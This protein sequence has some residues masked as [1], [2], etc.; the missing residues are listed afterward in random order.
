M[1]PDNAPLLCGSERARDAIRHAGVLLRGTHA[2]LVV[3]VGGGEPVVEFGAALARAGGF[4]SLTAVEVEG[5]R[6][7]AALIA[8]ARECG[9]ELIVAGSQGLSAMDSTLFGSVSSALVHLADRT[10][11]VVRPHDGEAGGPACYCYDG[12]PESLA[13]IE[14]GAR[15]LAGRE[16]V[17]ASFLQPVDDVVFLRMSLPRGDPSRV[18]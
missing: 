12:S 14:R 2:A 4:S 10:V 16:A 6:I 7:S 3:H 11:L 13:A 15:L 17:V 1:P 18:A 8:Q 9:A 5:D